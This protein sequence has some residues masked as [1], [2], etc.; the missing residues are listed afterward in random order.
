MP[1]SKASL[2]RLTN[3]WLIQF[4]EH[5]IGD[6]RVLRLIRK[7]LR[8][9]ISE[10]GQW[11]KTTV[12]APQGSVIS[13]LLSN[14]FLHYVFDPWIHWRR[15]QNSRGDVVVIRYA[16]DFVIGF[17]H[18]DEAKSCLEELHKRFAKFGLKLQAK[19]T[20]LIEF[21]RYA[22]KRRKERGEGRPE[23]FDFLGFTHKCA[24]SRKNGWFTVHRY[25]VTRRMRLKLQA[26]KAELRKRMHRPLIETAQWLRKVVQGWLNYHAVP[27]NYE[28]I[29]R[30]VDEI[31]RLWLRVIRRR[32][33]RGRRNWTW[34]RMQRFARRHLPFPRILHPYPGERYRARLKAGAV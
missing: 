12:G 14:V 11:S 7:W 25:S 13:P 24:K 8:A 33:Q 10:E 29:S 22:C 17:E 9:G 19:K 20:R 3:E 1:I 28:R 18:R 26:I 4:L 6:R 5:R 16:D 21:G 2:I 31:V 15:K 27:N 34:A 32:S 30:F 23:T